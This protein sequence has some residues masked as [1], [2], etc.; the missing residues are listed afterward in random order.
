MQEIDF[1]RTHYR[2][3]CRKEFL[4]SITENFN[5]VNQ[6]YVPLNTNVFGN[7]W[8]STL[9]IKTAFKRSSGEASPYFDQ[10]RTYPNHRRKV[11]HRP[12]G[13]NN[14]DEEGY[15]AGYGKNQQEVVIPAFLAA[16]AANP[17][18][19][20]LDPIQKVPL[21][22]WNLKYTGL[23]NMKSM[24]N[25]SFDSLTHWHCA[26]FINQF[27]PIWILIL[28]PQPK[29]QRREF[30]SRKTLRN[31]LVEQF[32][33]LIRVDMELKNSFKFLAEL[34]LIVRCL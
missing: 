13:S 7:F 8:I 32:N 20:S 10:F 4:E 26:S 12:C 25:C 24:K 22:N 9:L 28:L 30:R 18:N 34:K 6:E 2:P 23:M 16:Y 27:Q 19:I 3:Q 33:P 15:P 29:G 31:N 11:S 14:R 1:E 17:D 21:P 5:V